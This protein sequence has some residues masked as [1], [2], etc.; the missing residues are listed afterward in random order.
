MPFGSVTLI[1]GINV[2]RT[3]TLLEAGYSTCQ[4]GRFRDGLFQ[5]IGGFVKFYSFAVNGT[6][7]ELHAWED[8]NAVKHLGVGSTQQ[9]SV[10]TSGSLNDIT[11]QT[12]T[13]TPSVNFT[14]VSGSTQVEI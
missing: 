10:I 8:L 14:T 9:L 11:P 13:T 3:P 5:K 4:M 1:P 6:P 12:K 7:R 2:E